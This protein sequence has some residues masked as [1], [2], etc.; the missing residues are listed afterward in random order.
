MNLIYE[1]SEPIV[2]PVSLEEAKNHLRLSRDFT[3]DDELLKTLV[4]MA[5]MDAEA[6]TGGRVFPA[7]EWEWVPE[8]V[9]S[10]G[11]TYEIPVSPAL[12]I[13]AY[14][15]EDNAEIPSE[16]FRF[17]KSSL[18]P[19]GAPLFAKVIPA[20]DL[21]NVKFVVE[22]GW[23]NKSEERDKIYSTP[24]KFMPA[25][26]V[27]TE[28]SIAIQFDRAVFGDIDSR[29]F[30]VLV[31][32]DYVDVYDVDIDAGRV[33]IH[34]NTTLSED[35]K[36]ELSYTSGFLKDRDDNYV[37]P[38]MKEVLP[39][40]AFGKTPVEIPAS[41]K[42]TVSVSSVPAIVKSWILVRVSTL[43]QQRSEIAIQA[44]KTSNAFFPR[45]FINGMLDAYT[46]ERA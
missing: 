35:A 15:I 3:D 36:V 34:T 9:M 24:P 22:A 46:I 44:G 31:D 10:A 33:L 5:R 13:K 29:S 2:E 38:I 45:P 18:A 20:V 42:E 21:E 8:G 40:V 17:V 4:T 19:H 39:P 32:D 16:S 26:T 37:M 7:R 41:E 12:S 25:H 23:P 1:V 27:Y 28:N 30:T 14:N 6:K 43:Y 11:A